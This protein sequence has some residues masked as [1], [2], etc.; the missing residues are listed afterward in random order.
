MAFT[1]TTTCAMQAAQDYSALRAPDDVLAVIT[2]SA[3]SAL[4]GV[5]LDLD[6]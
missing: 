1:L 6:E 5:T 2:P 3:L 4:V